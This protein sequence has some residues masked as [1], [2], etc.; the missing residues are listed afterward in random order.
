MSRL[1]LD[2]LISKVFAL[3]IA[4]ISTLW[5]LRDLYS[6]RMFQDDY[7]VFSLSLV[8][9]LLIL[10]LVNMGLNLWMLKV[11]VPAFMLLIV[12][13]GIAFLLG[14]D[15]PLVAT[16]VFTNLLPSARLIMIQGGIL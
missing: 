12:V 14:R 11:G 13:D 3:G 4:L 16:W 8:I 6:V 2:S 9:L 5:L 1:D 10:M 15:Y 7:G